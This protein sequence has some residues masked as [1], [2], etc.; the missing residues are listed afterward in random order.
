MKCKNCGEEIESKLLYCPKCGESIQLVPEYD[1]LEE[2][3]LSRVVE[4]KKKAKEKFATG[5]YK[6]TSTDKTTISHKKEVC[7]KESILSK[8]S[9]IL[10]ITFL[11]I[12]SIGGTCIIAAYA[13]KHSYDNLMNMAIEAEEGTQYAKA[14][15]YYE[16][17]YEIKTDSYEAIYGLGRMYFKVKEYKKATE[18]LKLA[19]E[20]EPDNKKIY[21]YILESYVALK[22]YDSIRELADNAP[23]DEIYSMITSYFVSSPSFSE[24]GGEYAQNLT[25]YLKANSGDQIFYTTNGKNPVT[26]GKLYSDGISLK[27]GTTEIKAVALNSDGDYS[28][29]VSET[30]EIVYSELT[31]PEV[32]PAAGTYTDLQYISIAVPDNCTAY[33]TW[34]GSDPAVNGIV[35]TEPFP[36][37]SGSSVLSVIIIDSNG[38]QSPL[39]RGEY[40]YQT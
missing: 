22:D 18:Y 32:T 2:E 33:Y 25:V 36:I 19:L 24:P 26:S 14:L 4:D 39:Y 23:N 30:Y 13:N 9:T 5:V 20:Y 31:T 8:R 16:E 7:T 21:S 35:Y 3:L 15:G 1:V 28:E 29:V 40:H 37:I 11:L 6:T 34:D 38:N 17:A 12:I 10:L 27:E